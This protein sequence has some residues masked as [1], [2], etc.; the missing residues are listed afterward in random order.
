V[1]KVRVGDVLAL[2]RT[3]VQIDPT[4]EYVAIGI[5]SFGKGIFH[6]A[7]TQ[8]S[9]LSKLRYFEV[10]PNHLVVSNI[11]GWEGAIAVSSEAETGCIASNRFLT[12]EPID[13]SIDVGYA[14]YF[15][16]SEPG[17]RLIQQA[18][19]GSADRNRTLAI[20]RFEDL[21]IP[22]PARAEQQRIVHRV[23][24]VLVRAGQVVDR[25]EG[26]ADLGRSFIDGAVDAII[27]ASGEGSSAFPLGA[28]ATV[29]PRP[30]RIEGRVAFVPMSAVDERLGRIVD[31]ELRSASDVKS[32]YKQ[33]RR[34]D[35]IFAR[36][37]PCM[38]NGKSAVMD[39]EGVE[40]GYGSTEF[41][42]L[43]PSQRLNPEW[44]RHI[45][46][47]RDFRSRAVRAFTGTAGQQRVPADYLRTVEIPVPPIE[48]QVKLVARL[49]HIARIGLELRAQREREQRLAGALTSSTLND[50]FS[51]AG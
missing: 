41:H 35:V 30:A 9:A 13:E 51:W 5:R 7:P 10:R 39:V 1:N 48:I 40:Y 16:L 31:G 19:P 49:D 21:L 28:V 24:S 8:G 18:S 12:Y 33:F 25:V 27:K 34:G 29:N 23:E 42:V 45:L 14:H 26:A 47:S 17:L 4:R 22:L 20:Q 15:F 3:P 11:K 32:G 2:R 44:L 50:A 46:R 38:Q 6:Y 37:T 43:R 36:I